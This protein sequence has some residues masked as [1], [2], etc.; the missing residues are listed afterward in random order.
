MGL[1]V[2]GKTAGVGSRTAPAARVLVVFVLFILLVLGREEDRALP[3][4][5]TLR[6]Q[7]QAGR[8]DR[9]KQQGQ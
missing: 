6:G 7:D 2:T 5:G 8:A 4:G 9:Q 1:P 3:G